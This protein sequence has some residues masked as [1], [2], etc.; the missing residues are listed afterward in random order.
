[1]AQMNAMTDALSKDDERM[2][3]RAGKKI[4]LLQI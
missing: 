2:K 1:M 4:L 3:R